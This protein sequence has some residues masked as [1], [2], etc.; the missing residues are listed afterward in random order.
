M[1]NRRAAADLFLASALGLF[2]ELLFIRWVSAELRVFSFYR[3]LALIG[4]FLGLGL[5]FATYRGKTGA[6]WFEKYYLPLMALVSLAV[7]AVGRSRTIGSLT[8]VNPNAQELVWSQ[9][10]QSGQASGLL[11]NVLFYVVLLAVFALITLVFVP[12]G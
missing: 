9:V 8:N 2:V 7:I 6:P 11:A 5:G 12:L 3:N 4:A 10:A 1:T